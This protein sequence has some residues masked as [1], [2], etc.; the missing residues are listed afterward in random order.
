[1]PDI[2]AARS[3]YEGIIHAKR[4]LNV[5]VW[6]ADVSPLLFLSPASVLADQPSSITHLR[7]ITIPP[8]LCTL[9][10]GFDRSAEFLTALAPLLL[11]RVLLFEE[12]YNIS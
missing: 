1:M 12:L 9:R 2:I 6:C 4:Q 10:A 5:S 11:L 7:L 3:F 8:I